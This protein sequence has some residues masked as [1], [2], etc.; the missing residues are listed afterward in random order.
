MLVHELD[1][2]H[3]PQLDAL[4]AA[5][6]PEAVLAFAGPTSWPILG[7]LR[8]VDRG[9]H[10]VVV[11]CVNED[12]YRAVQA[13]PQFRDRLA[14]ALRRAAAVGFSS[15]AGWDARLYRELDI[16]AVYLPNG[17]HRVQPTGPFRARA[18]KPLLLCVGNFWP[19]KN[20]AGLLATL[21][22][23]AGDWELVIV[24]GPS[25][26]VPEVADEVRRLAAQDGRV[27]LFGPAEPSVV[28]AAMADA[29]VLLLP[30]LAEA[31][32]LVLV[33]AMSHGLPWIATP[34]CGSAHDH[35]GGLIR[36]LAEFPDAI[37]Q[38]LG[39]GD[40]RTA[41]G[42]AGR[43]H[44]EAAYSWDVVGPRYVALLEGGPLPALPSPDEHRAVPA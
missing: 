36:P 33:E 10:V 6:A 39:D 18:D 34:T 30:S 37:S 41:F 43:A 4:I 40:V 11:P 44:W 32:P 38:L 29:D 16:P 15:Y 1:G 3:G 21:R 14:E 13:N 42:A 22:E 2:D 19:E 24:G 7:A 23:A 26:A 9:P 8:H 20:H 25:S 17:T 31:T 12:G 35:A 28:S 5:R 27:T